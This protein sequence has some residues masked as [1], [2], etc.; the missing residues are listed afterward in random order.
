MVRDAQ[1]V[2]RAAEEVAAQNRLTIGPDGSVSAS[3]PPPLMGA[4]QA[5]LGAAPSPAMGEV[6]DLVR[7]AMAAADEVD[8]QITARL[9]ALQATPR[10]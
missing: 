4:Q 7:R 2:L 3:S 10:A 9:Q 8:S 6:A 5:M 1:S